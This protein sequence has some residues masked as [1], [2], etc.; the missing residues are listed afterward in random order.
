MPVMK[1][2]SPIREAKEGSEIGGYMY[3][4]QSNIKLL[5]L[6]QLKSLFN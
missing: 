2:E 5:I 4:L 3:P 1:G 6:N